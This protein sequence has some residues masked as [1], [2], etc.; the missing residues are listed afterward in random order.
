MDTSVIIGN[1]H[2]STRDSCERKRHSRRI[3]TAVV[4]KTTNQYTCADAGIISQLAPTQSM[5]LRGP[6]SDHLRQPSRIQQS[7]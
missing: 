4:M 1:E 5:V 6:S 2:T 7:G 3:R